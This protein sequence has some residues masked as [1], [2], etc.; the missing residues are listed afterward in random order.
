MWFLSKNEARSYALLYIHGLINSL[1][2][3][4]YLLIQTEWNWCLSLPTHTRCYWRPVWNIFSRRGDSILPKERN[5]WSFIQIFVIQIYSAVPTSGLML[6][7][8]KSLEINPSCNPLP[9]ITIG[10]YESCPYIITVPLPWLLR[11]GHKSQNENQKINEK[12]S[13]CLKNYNLQ[14]LAPIIYYTFI[15]SLYQYNSLLYFLFFFN[16]F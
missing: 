4:K 12:M 5:A 1:V 15:Y 9:R 14:R 2:Y 10:F 8:A 13:S 16:F 3:I 7:M 6:G 11:V